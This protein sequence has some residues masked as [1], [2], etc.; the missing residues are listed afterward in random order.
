EKSGVSERSYAQASGEG[1]ET[2]SVGSTENAGSAADSEPRT[3]SPASAPQS[4][5]AVQQQLVD[6]GVYAAL[7]P[8]GSLINLQA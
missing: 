6:S 7:Y 4:L 8:S 3:F 1:A 5:N 2:G